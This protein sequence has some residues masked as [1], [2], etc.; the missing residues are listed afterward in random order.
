MQPQTDP[1]PIPTPVKADVAPTASRQEV[2]LWWGGYAVRTML[3]SLAVC[4]LLTV[5]MI[6]TAAYYSRESAHHGTSA[7][8]WAYRVTALL[9]LMQTIRWVYRIAGFEYRLTSHRLFCIWG[10][11]FKS[12]QP[13]ALTDIK[14]VHLQQNFWDHWLGI[15]RLVIESNHDTAPLVLRGVRNAENVAR[16]IR[17]AAE[18]SREPAPAL[19]VQS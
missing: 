10:P 6:G 2:E 18:R 5:A 11:L 12:P 4:L 17:H 13:I 7:R 3:P 15:G 1:Q 19:P 16:T 8:W 14:T 9:W